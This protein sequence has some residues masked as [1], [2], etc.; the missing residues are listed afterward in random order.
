MKKKE[1]TEAIS[2][3][4]NYGPL[5]GNKNCDICIANECNTENSC[6][7]NP[8]SCMQYECHPEY[9]A[10]LFVNTNV[11]DNRN[12][13]SVLDY[14]VFSIDYESK[15]SVDR[16]CKY[17]DIIWEYIE[18]REIS[19]ESLEQFD[20]DIELLSDLNAI[21][22]VDGKIF[23]KIYQCCFKNPSEFLPNTQLVDQK[24]DSK[25]REWLGNDYKWKL[26][27]RASEHGYIAKTFHE[28]CD[29]KGP[30]L[31]VIKSR[32]GWIFGGYTTKSWN[33]DGLCIFILL[34]SNW[35]SAIKR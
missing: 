29:D 30:T 28:C 7:I 32:E 17:P 6:F 25:L 33:R 13:F 26:L 19:E 10:S 8:P 2:C 18:T 24:Y 12:A 35:N 14:E 9:N 22:C 4:P 34:L 27:Y 1:S 21:H 11:P 5:F 31:I 16:L 20:D 15:Y 3:Y 23:Q